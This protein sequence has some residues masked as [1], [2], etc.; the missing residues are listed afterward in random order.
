MV[1]GNIPDRPNKTVFKVKKPQD[2]E[3]RRDQLEIYLKSLVKR[4]ELRSNSY[5]QFFLEIDKH[6]PEVSM[7]SLRLQA[8]LLHHAHGFR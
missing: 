3:K 1:H 5:F 6:A 4:E 8:R 7:N 2:L